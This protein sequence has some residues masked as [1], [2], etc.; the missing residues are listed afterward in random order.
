VECTAKDAMCPFSGPR[1]Q[2]SQHLSSCPYVS[3]RPVLIK[4]KR[5]IEELRV[6]KNE[7]ME[8]LKKEV[9]KLR[10]LIS[11]LASSPVTKVPKL[12]QD[13]PTSM[14]KEL[15]T[16][17]PLIWIHCVMP[18]ERAVVKSLFQKHF[19]A[20][21]QDYEEEGKKFHYRLEKPDFFICLSSN[22][23]NQ[24]Q[25]SVT[26]KELSKIREQYDPRFVFMPG[27][28]GGN[29][30]RVKKGDIIVVERVV[31]WDGSDTAPL[32]VNSPILNLVH[33]TSISSEELVNSESSICV[34]TVIG[35]HQGRGLQWSQVERD[36]ATK[37]FGVESESLSLYSQFPTNSLC[38]KGVLDVDSENKVSN[39]RTMS[40]QLSATFVATF[41]QQ[42]YRSLLNLNEIQEEPKPSFASSVS[43]YNYA[44]GQKSISKVDHGS[45]VYIS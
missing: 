28:C 21:F 23:S 42:H 45:I 32:G 30:N 43:E 41:I 16:E 3:L 38:V 10:Q 19:K 37:V 33:G 9:D 27:I 36:L 17:K 5:E 44:Y 34:G 18:D 15:S 12:V 14:G 13:I 24:T 4:F 40:T 39:H 22:A 31:P 29:P 35:T 1:S 20:D 2:L 11:N 26:N 6:S 8:N 7:E 25:A